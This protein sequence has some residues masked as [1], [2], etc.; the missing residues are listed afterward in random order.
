[1]KTG[2]NTIALH[3]NDK[4]YT[5]E[6]H[7]TKHLDEYVKTSDL[8]E[9]V[10]NI[11]KNFTKRNKCSATKKAYASQNKHAA[12]ITDNDSYQEVSLSKTVS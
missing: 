4:R 8:S 9:T 7:S 1:L 11:E 2:I 10:G 6:P 12:V 3:F 5:L